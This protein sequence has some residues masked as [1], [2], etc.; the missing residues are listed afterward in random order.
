MHEEH[1]EFEALSEDSFEVQEARRNHT[2][3]GEP[4]EDVSFEVDRRTKAYIKAHR[5]PNDAET[6]GTV[7][8]HVLHEDPAL[9]VRYLSAAGIVRDRMLQHPSLNSAD[10]KLLVDFADLVVKTDGGSMPE[11][12][13]EILKRWPGLSNAYKTG[14]L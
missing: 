13:Q 11:R 2:L 4:I 12:L 3:A 9:S 8:K 5:L 1:I 10:G 14:T 7:L 6:Y